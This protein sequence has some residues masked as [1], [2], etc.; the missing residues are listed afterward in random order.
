MSDAG[1][2]GLLVGELKGVPE[3]VSLE[4]SKWLLSRDILL[5]LPPLELRFNSAMLYRTEGRGQLDT[6]NS[7]NRRMVTS[8]NQRKVSHP[9]LSLHQF[10]RQI[11]V[12]LLLLYM[13]CFNLHP[14]LQH[15]DV[16]GLSVHC[17]KQRVTL[18]D[19]ATTGPAQSVWSVAISSAW[20]CL[21]YWTEFWNLAYSNVGTGEV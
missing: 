21:R 14:F 9:L 5:E 18:G 10:R 15:V 16:V 12:E 17:G 13:R 3:S 11:L 2:E 19:I 1:L 7:Q 20:N 8:Q 6:D 4:V